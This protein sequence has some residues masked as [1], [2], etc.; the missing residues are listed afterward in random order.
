MCIRI[1]RHQGVKLNKKI[2]LKKSN[3]YFNIVLSLQSVREFFFGFYKLIF[4]L[5]RRDNSVLHSIRF[6]WSSQNAACVTRSWSQSAAGKQEYAQRLFGHWWSQTIGYL[7][8]SGKKCRAG[9]NEVNQWASSEILLC[10]SLHA[11]WGQSLFC[12]WVGN[13]A[14]C[15]TDIVHYREH[16]ASINPPIIP[17]TFSTAPPYFILFCTFSRLTFR[18]FPLSWW[19]IQLTICSTKEPKRPSS[20]AV[21]ATTGWEKEKRVVGGVFSIHG[22]PW[23]FLSHAFCCLS[24]V[25]SPLLQDKKPDSWVL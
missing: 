20:T 10:C 21:Q 17:P 9:R 19:F 1:S 23:L 12:M 13:L 8:M 15:P 16:G 6:C 24:V 11:A 14:C 2:C 5:K 7:F 22:H 25:F 4:Y 18:S 3:I